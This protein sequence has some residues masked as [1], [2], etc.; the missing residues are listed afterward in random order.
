MY[1]MRSLL[2]ANNTRNFEVIHAVKTFHLFMFYP[3][4]FV[5]ILELFEGEVTRRMSMFL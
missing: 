2:Y 1:S 3:D 5:A 4:S